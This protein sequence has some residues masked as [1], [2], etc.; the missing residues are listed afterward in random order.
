VPVIPEQ[1]VPAFQRTGCFVYDFSLFGLPRSLYTAGL[2]NRSVL[3]QYDLGAANTAW[4]HRYNLDRDLFYIGGRAY[5]DEEN[6][7]Y[8]ID[9][10][11]IF[12]LRQ[13]G[14]IMRSWTTFI[15]FL[16]EE[17]KACEQLML[18]EKNES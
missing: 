9:N 15:D 10:C 18:K 3:E 6:V 17:I 5:S 13:N 8:F 14:E 4:I 16:S 1:T 12:S 2:L 11:K 7:G